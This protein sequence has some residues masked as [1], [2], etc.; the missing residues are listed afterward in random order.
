MALEFFPFSGYVCVCVCV[1]VCM[2][3]CVLTISCCFTL[4][5]EFGM[6]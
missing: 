5:L 2:F 6:F 1:C 3:K 4:T